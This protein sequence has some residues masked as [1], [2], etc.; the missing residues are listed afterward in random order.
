MINYRTKLARGKNIRN[1]IKSTDRCAGKQET[2][3]RAVG[4]LDIAVL[5]GRKGNNGE[6]SGWMRHVEAAGLSLF[7][8]PNFQKHT[9]S[10]VTLH[11]THSIQPCHLKGAL[12]EDNGTVSLFLVALPI[13]KVGEKQQDSYAT[14][15]YE[16]FFQRSRG[17]FISHLLFRTLYHLTNM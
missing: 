15:T 17:T 12:L 10:L 8:I 1:K 5:E 3:K 6:S 4:G 16:D 2:Y 7:Y 13:T 9:P 11:N 14:C